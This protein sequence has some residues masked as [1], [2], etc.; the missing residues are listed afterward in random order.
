MVKSKEIFLKEIA[1]I[2]EMK[3]NIV[4]LIFA[5]H[6]EIDISDKTKV[7]ERI[8]SFYKRYS[9]GKERDTVKIEDGENEKEIRDIKEWEGSDLRIK[10]VR[11]KSVRGYPNSEKPFGFSLTNDE[12]FPKSMI[13][14]GANGVGKSS[15][16]CAMEY[17]FCQAIGETQLRTRKI[18]DVEDFEEYL[19][20]D[21]K[22]FINSFCQIETM[23]NKKWFDLKEV[24][25]PPAVRNKINSATHFISDHDIYSNGQLSYDEGGADSFQIMIAKSLGLE[26]LLLFETELKSFAAYKRLK[27]SKDISTLEKSNADHKRNIDTNTQAVEEKNKQLGQIKKTQTTSPQDKNVQD[28]LEILTSIKTNNFSFPYNYE[29]LLKSIAEY[30]NKYNEFW[31][32]SNKGGNVKE[33]QFL[34]WGLELLKESDG[35]PFCNNS[36]NAKADIETYVRRRIENIKSLNV[37]LQALTQTFN[38]VLEQLTSLSNGV[39]LLRSKIVKEQ[40]MITSRSDLSSLYTNEI[41][42]IEYL[43]KNQSED[44]FINLQGFQDNRDYI[45]DKNRFLFELL[46]SNK[47]Y[48]EIQLKGFISTLS[49]FQS[50]REELLMTID[51]K[52]TTKADSQTLIQQIAS[53]EAEIKTLEN[54]ATFART[55]IKNNE[56][57][58]FRIREVQQLFEK[59]QLQARAYAAAVHTKLSVEIDQAFR[60]IQSIVENILNDYL[61]TDNKDVKI[62]VL[63]DPDIVDEETGEILS[64]IITAKVRLPNSNEKPITVNRYFNTFYYRLFSTMVGLSVAIASRKNTKINMPLVLDDVFYASDFENRAKI[65]SFLKNVFNIFRDHTPHLKLQLIMFTHDQLIF[66]SALKASYDNKLENTVFAK[67]FPPDMADDAGDYKNLIYELPTYLPQRIYENT[68]VSL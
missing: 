33:L 26:Q 55:Q 65:E 3:D 2:P 56:E 62:E 57:E 43:T 64:E 67:M 45:K 22:G 40:N 39:V 35:C 59:I 10:N 50:K 49:G 30:N 47:S 20:S 13:I 53:L 66:E 31:A 36:N 19:Q 1:L 25:I 63:K 16:Y 15:L 44:L 48:I 42:F 29:G 11:I 58:I 37:S 21:N 46:E 23:K 27:E 68:T 8:L 14:L 32:K 51:N 7:Y 52:L 61:K 28:T 60:P 24:N 4:S 5:L 6:P 54:N 17:I 18:L 34:D 38:I 12:G 9:S 41:K